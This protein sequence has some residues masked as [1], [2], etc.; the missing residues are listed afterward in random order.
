[1]VITLEAIAALVI[2]FAA[3]KPTYEIDLSGGDI[4]VFC[5]KVHA[6]REASTQGDISLA[7]AAADF[8][9]QAQAFRDLATVAPDALRSDL[10][11]LAALSD[12]L[13]TAA[14]QINA[15]KAADPSYLGGLSDLATKQ[16]DVIG[17]GAAAS[18]KLDATV[19]AA[20]AIDLN[21]PG[22][23]T[24]TSTSTAPAAPGGTTPGS[25]PR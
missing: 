11:Q 23:S 7:T 17:R 13:V 10:Q 6:I 16:G 9:K 21:A 5:V 18:A 1:V 22:T 19:S 14:N 15:K 3:A 20:C 4:P 12:E 25:A 8:T 24:S 2:S